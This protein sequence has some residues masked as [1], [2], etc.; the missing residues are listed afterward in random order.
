MQPFTISKK[1]FKKLYHE[2]ENTGKII[3]PEEKSNDCASEVT[4][5]LKQKRIRKDDPSKP[6]FAGPWA[7]YIGEAEVTST[8]YTPITSATDSAP[9]PEDTRK[10]PTEFERKPSYIEQEVNPIEPAVKMHSNMGPDYQ[11]RGL[12]FPPA[13][14]NP[15]PDRDTKLPKREQATYTDHTAAVQAV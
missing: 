1:T 3:D 2:F 11:G 5:Q 14:L 12:L 9:A 15:D 6:E 13:H 4:K 7:G 8:K 10:L